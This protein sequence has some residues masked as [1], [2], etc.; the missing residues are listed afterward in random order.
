MTFE[1]LFVFLY[2]EMIKQS[3]FILFPV[4]LLMLLTQCGARHSYPPELAVLDSL[5]GCQADSAIILLDSLAPLMEHAPEATRRYFQLLNIKV[6]DKA[7]L[8]LTDDSLVSQLVGY[9]END[10]DRHLL[11]TMLGVPSLA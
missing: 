10:G 4:T 7:N 11:T 8:P 5:A 1:R 9:Y 2:A 6:R 3:W